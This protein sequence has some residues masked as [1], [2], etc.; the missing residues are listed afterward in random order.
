MAVS[1]QGDGEAFQLCG[2]KKC[3]FCYAK[4][5]TKMAAELAVTQRWERYIIINFYDG[6]SSNVLTLKSFL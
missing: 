3:I 5:E 6:Y 1:L 4:I 2:K